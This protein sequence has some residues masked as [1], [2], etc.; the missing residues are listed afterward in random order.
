MGMGGCV[1]VCERLNGSVFRPFVQLL[2]IEYLY[3]FSLQS[4]AFDRRKKTF[5]PIIQTKIEKKINEEKTRLIRIKA[6]P[7]KLS[8]ELFFLADHNQ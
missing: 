2:M 7:K 4:I 3:F 6:T 1:C 5:E 8:I